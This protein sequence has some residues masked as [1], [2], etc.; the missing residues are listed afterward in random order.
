[1]YRNESNQSRYSHT[2]GAEP[3]HFWPQGI[4]AK[5]CTHI[6]AGN[7]F[8]FSEHPGGKLQNMPGC[9]RNGLV[10]LFESVT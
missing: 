2:Q 9:F 5:P 10:P 8:D 6:A 1:M 3:A 4:S 7:P